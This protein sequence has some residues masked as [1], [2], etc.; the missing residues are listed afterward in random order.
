MLKGLTALV[1]EEEFL[2]ALDFQRML[3][4]LN[5]G[6]TIFAR[7]PAEAELLR[8]QWPDIALA[9]VDISSNPAGSLRLI[10]DLEA[11]GIPSVLTVTDLT[12][13]IAFAR[14]KEQLRV[15]KP[16]AETVMALAVA[17]ALTMRLE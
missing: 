3:E 4:G 8:S 13:P 17:Q 6:Q 11:A 14:D 10:S 15:V 16:V 12:I 9:I 2:I 7:S 1:V 5:V